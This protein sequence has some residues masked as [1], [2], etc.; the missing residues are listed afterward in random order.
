MPVGFITFRFDEHHGVI[1]KVDK[2]SIPF[3][4]ILRGIHC[5]AF[6]LKAMTLIFN[7]RWDVK[8][9][10]K[11]DTKKISWNISRPILGSIDHAHG[12]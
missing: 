11:S 4:L 8:K 2:G 12:V 7:I 9:V 10:L 6:A 5:G 3:W 1:L